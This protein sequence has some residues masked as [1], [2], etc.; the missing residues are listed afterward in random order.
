VDALLE[1]VR[2]PIVS[3][4]VDGDDYA[5]PSAVDRLVAP[6]TSA[7]VDRWHH[8]P[9][10]AKMDHFRWVKNSAEIAAH[11]S[12]WAAAMVGKQHS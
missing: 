8:V 1:S 4:S 10:A 2:L 5:P 7:T 6:L 12:A 11:I 9:T 3:V